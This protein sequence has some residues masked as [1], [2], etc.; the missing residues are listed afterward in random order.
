MTADSLAKR[1]SG[2]GKGTRTVGTVIAG[3]AVGSGLG[4]A[5]GGKKGAGIGALLGS[6]GSAV[7]ALTRK[8]LKENE[9]SR[10]YGRRYRR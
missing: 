10:Y 1:D 4:A 8:D 7:Y 2:Y 6:G 3:T 5:I 9:R